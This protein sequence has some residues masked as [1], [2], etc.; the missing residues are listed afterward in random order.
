MELKKLGFGM[1]RLPLSNPEDNTQI[2]YDMVCK[3]AD[4]Y[5]EAGFNYFDTAAPYHSNNTR[6]AFRSTFLLKYR[7]RGCCAPPDVCYFWTS[8]YSL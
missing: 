8:R 4:A 2:D 1:M 5:M 6:D 7:R 3:M